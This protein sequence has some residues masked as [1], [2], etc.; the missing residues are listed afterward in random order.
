MIVAVPLLT[1]V[2]NPVVLTEAILPL[3]LIQVPPVGVLLRL[4]VDP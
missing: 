2:T 1:P 3:L 4:V